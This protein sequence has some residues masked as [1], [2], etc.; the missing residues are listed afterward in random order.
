MQILDD[1]STRGFVDLG[2]YEPEKC[3]SKIALQLGHCLGVRLHANFEQLTTN[4]TTAK[5]QNTY[6]GNY[7]FSELPLHT[8]LAHWYVPPRYI[9]LR[10]V[11][12]DP[13]VSTLLLHHREVVAQFSEAIVRRALFRPRRRLEGKLFLMRLRDNGIFR[14]DQ[15]FLTPDNHE[16]RQVRNLMIS[17]HSSFKIMEEVTLAEP[18]RTILIDNWNTLHGRSLVKTIPSQRRIQRIYFHEEGYD[19]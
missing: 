10:C 7:G 17:P 8:D 9:L 3:I 18:G 19:D 16:A 13:E 1:I 14:W 15:L 5:P 2:I 6:A 12:G 4:S 11:V